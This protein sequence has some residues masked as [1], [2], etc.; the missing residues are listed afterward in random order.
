M[1]QLKYGN[2]PHQKPAAICSIND[3]ELPFQVINGTPGYIN[4]LDAINAWQLVSE[5]RE[6]LGSSPLPPS[7]PPTPTVVSGPSITS[8]QSVRRP[9]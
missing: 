8:N 3:Q 4:L 7:L 1:L 9:C 5:A 6:A 2:N